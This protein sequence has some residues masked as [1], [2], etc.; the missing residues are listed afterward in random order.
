MKR[1]ILIFFVLFLFS[2]ASLHA[3]DMGA[4]QERQQQKYEKIVEIDGN[5]AISFMRYLQNQRDVAEHY[6]ADVET[7]ESLAWGYSRDKNHVYDGK[8]VLQ[9]DLTTFRVI[10][11]GYAIDKNYIYYQWSRGWVTILPSNRSFLKVYHK[12]FAHNLKDYFFRWQYLAPRGEISMIINENCFLRSNNQATCF[13]EYWSWT[14]FADWE[15]I[16]VQTS[17][18][19]EKLTEYLYKDTNAVYYFWSGLGKI[20]ISNN[21]SEFKIL[22]NR[23]IKDDS[24]V[25]L[26]SLDRYTLKSNIREVEWVDART[27]NVYKKDEEVLPSR[28]TDDTYDSNDYIYW[29]DKNWVFKSWKLDTTINTDDFDIKAY[30]NEKRSSDR[31]AKKI[32]NFKEP[33]NILCLFIGIFLSFIVHIIYYTSYL[34][35]KSITMTFS[36]KSFLILASILLFSLFQ[37]FF[38]WWFIFFWGSWIRLSFITI[39][40]LSLWIITIML[41]TKLLYPDRVNLL[42]DTFRFILIVIP[43]IVSVLFSILAI[44]FLFGASYAASMF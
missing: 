32:K 38:L 22:N 7:F 33:I 16:S 24:S 42:K 37:Y 29:Y 13:F 1:L 31:N 17:G 41:R 36:A 35:K 21:P 18:D 15:S 44:L 12:N 28:H 9:A 3:F 39:S 25:W 26:V 40:M 5:Q 10:E 27:F 34:K 14:G 20:L 23:Y 8:G 6:G 19:L 30:L 11:S 2:F 43:I 4:Y